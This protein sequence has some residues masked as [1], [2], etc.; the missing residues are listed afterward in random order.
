MP[1]NKLLKSVNTQLQKN[2]SLSDCYDA[3]TALNDYIKTRKVI[4]RILTDYNGETRQQQIDQYFQIRRLLETIHGI[5]FP[6]TAT[7]DQAQS[8]KYFNLEWKGDRTA[9]LYW[10]SSHGWT[11]EHK[12]FDQE[13]T[14]VWQDYS[15]EADLEANQLYFVDYVDD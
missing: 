1:T 11:V 4:E 13:L 2:P 3:L 9:R 8:T 5:T 12:Q 7:D 14:G 15:L 6:R 10:S